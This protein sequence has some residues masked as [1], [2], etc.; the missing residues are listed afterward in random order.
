LQIKEITYPH[1]T[2]SLQF[3][4]LHPEF[5]YLSSVIYHHGNYPMKEEI[6]KY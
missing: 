6:I 2:Y 1:I 3:F 4:Q 5:S